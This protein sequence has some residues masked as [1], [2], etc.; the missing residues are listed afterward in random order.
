MITVGEVIGAKPI[1]K[2]L[3]D[4]IVQKVAEARSLGISPA[5][6]II[7]IGKDPASEF[8]FNAKI[9]RAMEFGVETRTITMDENAP[10][11]EVIGHIDDLAADSSVHGIMIEAPVPSHLDY[12]QLVN[13]IPWY[14][15][16]DGATFENLGR[17]M[18]GQKCLV[19]ATPLAV[20]EYI[21]YMGIEQGSMV[22]VINRT[23]TVGRPLSQLLL[24]SNFTP[25]VCHSKTK[26]IGGIVRGSDAVVV[27]AGKAGFLTRELVDSE[28]IVIDVGINS[29][30]GKIAGDAD[31]ESLKDYVKA[32][33]P[34]PGG[35]GSLTSLLI[36]SNLLLS[37][38]YQIELSNFTKS[39]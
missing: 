16:I 20:M 14:K 8:Y 2:Y 31:F 5:M 3:K 12:K 38:N 37:I 13:R 9:K 19:A 36:F 27:A 23:I 39:S 22:A 21:R 30:D 34:V 33:T 11:K 24:N 25:V 4:D 1:M 6:A 29:V 7:R 28:S 17:L 10:E 26:N 18:S 32:I 15:D 35:V